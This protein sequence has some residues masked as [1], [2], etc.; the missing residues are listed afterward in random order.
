VVRSI[1]TPDE[2][3]RRQLPA[4]PTVRYNAGT[5]NEYILRSYRSMRAM[6]ES[7]LTL[8]IAPSRSVI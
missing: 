2:T 1:V 4:S 7:S 8:Q 5:F 3:G 6:I